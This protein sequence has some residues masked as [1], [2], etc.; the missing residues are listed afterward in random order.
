MIVI[1]VQSHAVAGRAGELLV[2]IARIAGL[3]RTESGN[4]GYD[5]Y[6]GVEQPDAICTIERWADSASLELHRAA[7]HIAEYV[8]AT[9]NLIA[10]RNVLI[11]ETAK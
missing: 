5:F 9:K 3:S 2:N 10:S 11:H 6:C 7:P 1:L 8:T 4:V